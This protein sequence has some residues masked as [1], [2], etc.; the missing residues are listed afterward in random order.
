MTN[1]KCTPSNTVRND[2]DRVCRGDEWSV[3][4]HIFVSNVW[5]NVPDTYVGKRVSELRRLFGRRLVIRQ[6]AK[7]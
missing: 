3:D 6:K 7:A 4:H 5:V 2:K 1:T